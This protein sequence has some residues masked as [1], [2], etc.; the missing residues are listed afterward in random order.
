[1]GLR[2]IEPFHPVEISA[3][4][5]YHTDYIYNVFIVA[6]YAYLAALNGGLRIVDVSNPEH[7]V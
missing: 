4:G 7:P 5:N 6:R 1:M 3:V 2:V